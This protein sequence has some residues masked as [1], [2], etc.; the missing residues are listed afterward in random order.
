MQSFHTIHQNILLEFKVAFEHDLLQLSRCVQGRSFCFHQHEQ[1]HCTRNCFLTVESKKKFNFHVKS[2]KK[3]QVFHAQCL[4]TLAGQISLLDNGMFLKNT[5]H[6]SALDKDLDVPLQC[7]Q[8]TQENNIKC[9]NY[10]SNSKSFQSHIMQCR[11]NNIV[12]TGN[13]SYTNPR[14]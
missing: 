3:L 5:T 1:L 8:Q 6:Y 2:Y 11:K 14:L 4:H 9:K 12:V 7:T 13:D 10:F